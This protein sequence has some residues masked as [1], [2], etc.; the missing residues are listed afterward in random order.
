LINQTLRESYTFANTL[1]LGR[2]RDNKILLLP[3]FDKI[4]FLAQSNLYFVGVHNYVDSNETIEHRQGL[5]NPRTEKWLVDTTNFEIPNAEND[6]LFFVVK[7]TKT[8]KYG[9]IDTTGKQLANFTFDSIGVV[10]GKK[11]SFWAKKNN[12]FQILT[13]ENGKMN[14]H[15]KAYQFLSPINFY[16]NHNAEYELIHYFL[17]KTNDKWG[18]I[19]FDEKTIKPFDYDYATPLKN[20][21]FLLVKN[22]QAECFDV[23]SLPNTTPDFPHLRYDEGNKKASAPYLV[24][25][26]SDRVF[27]MN[28]AGK[29]LIPPQ[30]KAIRS[31]QN[32]AYSL[33]EDAQKNKKIIFSETGEVVDFPFDF[34]ITSAYPKSRVLAVKDSIEFGHGIVS[35]AGKTLIPCVNFG[36]SID[37]NLPVFFVKRDTPL[38][39]RDENFY[40]FRNQKRVSPDSLNIEDDGWLMYHADGQLLDKKPFRFPIQFNDGIGVGMKENAFNLY[41]SDGSILMPFGEKTG[42]NKTESFNNIRRDR[43]K[44]FY[45]LFRNQGLTPTMIFT[46]KTGKIIVESGRYDGISR[47]YDKYAIV[48]AKGKIGLIDSFGREIIAPKDLRTYTEQFVDSLDIIN[49]IRRKKEKLGED[50]SSNEYVQLP[51]DAD[52][53]DAPNHPDSLKIISFHRASLWNLMLEKTLPTTIGNASD[54]SIERAEKSNEE[55]V[56]ITESTANWVYHIQRISVADS[57]IGFVFRDNN[58]DEGNH[59]FF[60]NFYRRNARWEELKIN[61]LLNIQGEKRGLF[62]EFLSQK[63]KALKDVSIDCSN[64]SSFIS[65]VENRFLLTQKGVDFCFESAESENDFVIVSFSWNDLKPYLK[66]QIS[67]H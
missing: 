21:A 62:N 20:N 5:F 44:G 12:K 8:Q 50:F 64:S 26:N 61:D 7:N 1:G 65:Q 16:F 45:A 48:S 3:K 57:T 32:S 47:F 37:P 18:L 29:I 2:G 4:Q 34:R 30:Y 38:I 15:K 42:S 25:D 28:N 19:D 31:E 27:F 17:A 46:E 9:I 11:G 6:A 53:M 55:F 43:S 35:T 23:Q 49:K 59:Q 56:N 54:L 66:M 67:G 13:I 10:D 40:A 41:K 60:Y 14:L 51:I 58:Y 24:A 33:V 63:I 36:V 22:N 52:E 39:N